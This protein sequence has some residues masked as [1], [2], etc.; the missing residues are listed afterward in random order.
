MHGIDPSD[1]QIRYASGRPDA[2]GA[3]FRTGN[4]QSLPFDNDRF[5]AA[6]MALVIFFVPDPAKGVAE[7]ARVVAG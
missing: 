3:V 7:M 6:V 5:D 1:A 2:P 4:A